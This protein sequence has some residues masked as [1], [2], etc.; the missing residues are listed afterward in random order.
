MYLKIEIY[1]YGNCRNIPEL[2]EVITNL[3]HN[4]VQTLVRLPTVLQII[5]YLCFFFF[6]KAF[7]C[8]VKISIPLNGLV[9]EK[10]MYTIR[11]NVKIT[12]KTNFLRFYVYSKWNL[13]LLDRL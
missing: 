11:N 6:T 13:L 12:I 8:T 10:T 7:D 2:Y 5:Q 4:K 9:F 3:K 1:V